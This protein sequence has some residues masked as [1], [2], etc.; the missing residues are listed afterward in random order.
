M[1]TQRKEIRRIQIT[2]D[3]AHRMEAVI[4]GLDDGRLLA[5]MV[6][7]L[8]KRAELEKIRTWHEIHTLAGI[9]KNDPNM[10]VMISWLTNELVVYERET[11]E[12]LEHHK[13]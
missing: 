1:S 12:Q 6:T 13:P 3:Q 4:C 5:S 9:P 11:E 7:E 8:I 2:E 10:G